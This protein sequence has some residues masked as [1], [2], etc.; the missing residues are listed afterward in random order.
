MW[1]TG[2]TTRTMGTTMS[3]PS[4]AANPLLD[5]PVAGDLV[6]LLDKYLIDLGFSAWWAESVEFVALMVVLFVALTAIVG[7]LLPLLSDKL[8][9]RVDI[10][11]EVVPAVLLAPEWLVT[12]SLVRLNRA[13]G[14][15]VYGYGDAVHA[16]ADAA[17]QVIVAALRL[18]GTVARFPRSTVGLLLVMGLLF[19]NS[20]YCAGEAYQCVSPVQQWVQLAETLERPSSHRSCAQ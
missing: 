17:R 13:P 19:W 2:Q 14:C 6:A 1:W 15:F 9:E 4:T 11:V 18:F 20:E 8:L 12:K 16:L 3:S 5:L 7:K 10:F